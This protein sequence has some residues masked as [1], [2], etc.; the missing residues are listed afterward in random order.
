MHVPLAGILRGIYFIAVRTTCL[1]QQQT[2]LK[3][4][5]AVSA[6]L[7]TT[8]RRCRQKSLQSYPALFTKSSAKRATYDQARAVLFA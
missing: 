5:I 6:Q 3:A 4:V 8:C 1:V 2:V 7:W